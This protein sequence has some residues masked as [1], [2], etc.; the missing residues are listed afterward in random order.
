MA[1][2][3]PG[4]QLPRM[5]QVVWTSALLLAACSSPHERGAQSAAD[6]AAPASDSARSPSD[7]GKGGVSASAPLPSTTARAADDSLTTPE[8]VI[9]DFYA[10]VNAHDYARAYAAWGS[11]GP[12]GHPTEQAFAAGYATTDSV[13]VD[14]GAPGRMD[15]AAGSRYVTVPVT[16]HAFM[17]GGRESV[18]AGS[19]DLRR[20]VV[21]GASAAERRW[22]LYR[23]TL[24]R[25]SGE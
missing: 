19:Y 3:S 25:R 13:R 20:V 22:H 12:P 17:R 14:V 23:A 9:R 18:Y 7:S 11:G 2:E 10:A 21:D 1:P 4:A 8:N 24:R 6:S 15:A 5:R 16:V